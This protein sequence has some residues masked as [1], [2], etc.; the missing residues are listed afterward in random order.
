[1][2]TGQ[3]KIQSIDGCP[4]CGS[5][6]LDFR[7]MEYDGDG[8]AAETVECLECGTSFKQSWKLVDRERVE[9]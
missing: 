1:M 8:K 4:E 7:P 2:C 3:A 6:R 9:R 5:N